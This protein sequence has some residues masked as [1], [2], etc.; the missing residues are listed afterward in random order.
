M[1]TIERGTFQH[2][3]L[4]WLVAIGEQD[5]EIKRL[6]NENSQLRKEITRLQEV[7]IGGLAERRNK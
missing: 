3:Y 6:Q 2:N 5:K 4:A 7:I 1:S